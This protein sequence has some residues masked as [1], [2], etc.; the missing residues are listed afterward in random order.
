MV[1][2]CVYD[3]RRRTKQCDCS[4]LISAMTTAITTIQESQ[5]VFPF[6]SVYYTSLGT[7]STKESPSSVMTLEP[8]AKELLEKLIKTHNVWYRPSA[9]D[10]M[11]ED[12]DMENYEMESS[13]CFKQRYREVLTGS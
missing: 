2:G 12:V 3:E 4:V 13:V 6:G 9:V 5:V 11:V 1:S 10:R 7:L 8:K